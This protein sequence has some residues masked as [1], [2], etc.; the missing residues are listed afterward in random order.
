MGIIVKNEGIESD[1]SFCT[2]GWPLASPKP[3]QAFPRAKPTRNAIY[4]KNASPEYQMQRK[5]QNHEV[6]SQSAGPSSGS[7][8]SKR[9]FSGRQHV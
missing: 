2:F 8:G 6:I 1:S 9:V 4:C 7:G 3:K 5:M